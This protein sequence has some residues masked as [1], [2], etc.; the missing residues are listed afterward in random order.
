MVAHREEKRSAN[1][2][3]RREHRNAI[4]FLPIGI[5]DET[6][7]ETGR[8]QL[9][10]LCNDALAFIADHE[11][12]GFDPCAGQGIQDGRNQRA[13]KDWNEWLEESFIGTT[14]T[15]T[16]ARHQNYCLRN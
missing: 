5:F 1:V 9:L 14:H 13:T 3:S 7:I 15:R 12:D 11:V 16:L 8:N 2:A 6:R 10:D 4:L